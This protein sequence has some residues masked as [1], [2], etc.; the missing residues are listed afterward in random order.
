MANIG[1]CLVLSRGEEWLSVHTHRVQALNALLLTACL[2]LVGHSTLFMVVGGAAFVWLTVPI[3][4]RSLWLA[5]REPFDI[6]RFVQRW[7][8][9]FMATALT[10][11]ALLLIAKNAYGS[12]A[13]WGGV[14]LFGFELALTSLLAADARARTAH[15]TATQP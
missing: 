11:L 12:I 2:A 5:A 4:A 8:P 13:W 15:T 10:V 3:V 14:I 1:M 7:V 9:V 6:F